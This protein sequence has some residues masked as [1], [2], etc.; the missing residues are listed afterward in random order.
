M[1]KKSH[2][3]TIILLVIAFVVYTA[4]PPPSHDFTFRRLCVCPDYLPIRISF[5]VRWYK[6]DGHM[7]FDNGKLVW[8]KPIELK[9]NYH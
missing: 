9:L 8:W 5:D 3:E 7:W 1:R 4:Y 6:H 2:S